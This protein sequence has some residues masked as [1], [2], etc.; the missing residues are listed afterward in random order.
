MSTL[1][2]MLSQYDK[3]LVPPTRVYRRSGKVV[4][5]FEFPQDGVLL[6][7][8]R[9]MARG[10]AYGRKVRGLRS[11]FQ[12][13]TKSIGEFGAPARELTNPIWADGSDVKFA[14]ELVHLFF[15]HHGYYSSPFEADDEDYINNYVHP[16]DREP[17]L[18]P[19]VDRPSWDA[20]WE[21]WLAHGSKETTRQND[22]WREA[23]A[24]AF[25]LDVKTWRRI[26]TR[27]VDEWEAATERA[28]KRDA[29]RRAREAKA[30]ATTT[31]EQI[32]ILN[33]IG[34]MGP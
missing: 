32:A 22:A 29:A 31:Q 2:G 19:V 30:A 14:A 21:S 6:A 27:L 23:A 24:A 16:S 15:W 11:W 10:G 26:A 4:V 33:R 1:E 9:L 34:G 7:R 18:P 28:F 25:A 12:S 13:M 3:L 17:P 8:H 20:H 5:A